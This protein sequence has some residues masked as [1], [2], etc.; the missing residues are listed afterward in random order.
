M[1]ETDHGISVPHMQEGAEKTK[2]KTGRGGARGLHGVKD[3]A[4]TER[5]VI[6]SY[7]YPSLT[8]VRLTE[9]TLSTCRR[10][11]SQPYHRAEKIDM[12]YFEGVTYKL[13]VQLSV[14]LLPGLP[15]SML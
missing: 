7:R 1:N 9:Y 4:P 3:D 6:V 8:A 2:H 13:T 11:F 5:L 10:A 14:S 15:C 12:F